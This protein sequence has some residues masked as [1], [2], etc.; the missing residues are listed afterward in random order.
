M[1]PSRFLE[2]AF[3]RQGA[4]YFCDRL[5]ISAS[6]CGAAFF[7]VL[8]GPVNLKNTLP[9]EPSAMAPRRANPVL[10]VLGPPGMPE[11]YVP[12][13]E[14]RVT[15]M[16]FT[17]S[18]FR[19]GLAGPASGVNCASQRSM[20]ASTDPPSP[21]PKKN[22]PSSPGSASPEAAG[23]RYVTTRIEEL[24]GSAVH[25]EGGFQERPPACAAW[26]TS[27]M[28]R[29]SIAAVYR[30]EERQ[31]NPRL[32]RDVFAKSVWFSRR[33]LRRRPRLRSIRTSARSFRA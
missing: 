20:F 14:T 10:G 15:R 26:A 2:M 6:N 18:T 29:S 13:V 30:F 1:L 27:T 24:G 19:D 22:T 9:P 5:W 11:L 28:A 33:L 12:S 31:R 4:R 16:P 32:R 8:A 21:L 17:V 23:T 25:P 7:T 3:F